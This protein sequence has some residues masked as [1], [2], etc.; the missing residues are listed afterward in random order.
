MPPND[1][2]VLLFIQTKPTI[3]SHPCANMARCSMAGMGRVGVRM[4]SAQSSPRLSLASTARRWNSTSG[5]KS[6]PRSNQETKGSGWKGLSVLGLMAATGVA[7][8][9]AVSFKNGRKVRD[10]SDPQKFLEPKYATLQDMEAVSLCAL[11]FFTLEC[12][13][14]IQRLGEERRSSY[15]RTRSYILK[16]CACNISF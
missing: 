14:C 2:R 3:K 6:T 5:S 16:I 4:H 10:Y 15:V 11:L 12:F 8:G 7:T 9:L 13:C 1:R